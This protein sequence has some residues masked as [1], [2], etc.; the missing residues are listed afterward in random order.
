MTDSDDNP[1]D[2]TI[3]DL[4][5]DILIPIAEATLLA[6]AFDEAT[7]IRDSQLAADPEWTTPRWF[8]QRTI[9]NSFMYG[10]VSSDNLFLPYRLPPDFASVVNLIADRLNREWAGE[11]VGQWTLLEA[12]A[13]LAEWPMEHPAYRAWVEDPPGAPLIVV[14]TRY[15]RAGTGPPEDVSRM[16]HECVAHNA[17]IYLRNDH[18][19]SEDFDRKL[20]SSQG[21]QRSEEHP[22]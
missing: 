4:K 1:Q 16:S 6:G 14:V 5:Q 8:H 10:I 17:A 21:D 20:L 7:A 15:D 2:Y 13:K 12:K 3:D 19:R 22:Q 11:E 9:I 18:R